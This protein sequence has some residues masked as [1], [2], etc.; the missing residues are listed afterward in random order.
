LKLT[1]HRGTLLT[2]SAIPANES[3]DPRL[4]RFIGDCC[5]ARDAGPRLAQPGARFGEL[6]S[7][8]DIGAHLGLDFEDGFEHSIICGSGE[9]MA[10]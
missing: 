3:I 9:G 7:G 5:T 1:E 6:S 8:G 2:I 10:R 4:E